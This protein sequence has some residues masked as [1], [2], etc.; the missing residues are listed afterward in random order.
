MSNRSINL[1]DDLYQY[2]LKVSLREHPVQAALREETAKLTMAEM[3]ISPEQGQF[4]AMLVHLM[5][6]KRAIEVGVF[7]GYSTLSVAM[8]LPDDGELIACDVSEEWTTLAREYWEKAGVDQKIKLRI[9]PAL[10]T[11]DSLIEEGQTGSFDFA[12]IDAD[13]VN[14][15]NY[16]ERCLK[17]LRQGGLVI[18]DNVLRDG[19]VIDLKKDGPSIQAS[20]ALNEKLL[21]DE[22][23]EISMLPVSDGLTLLRKR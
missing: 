22:R 21:G 20:R 13:K 18:I 4:M 5:G 19:A 14:N 12:F 3:Q 16:Y 11:L 23:V 8:A 7:T 10:E 6:A 15:D 1:T 17:L 2:L 9:A